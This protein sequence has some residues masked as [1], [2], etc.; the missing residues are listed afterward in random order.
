LTERICTARRVV[1][2]Q[3]TS[4]SLHA[5]TD[6]TDTADRQTVSC[7]YMPTATTT[8]WWRSELVESV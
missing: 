3:S 2:H 5:Q 7:F 6:A 4:T 8:S 1:L